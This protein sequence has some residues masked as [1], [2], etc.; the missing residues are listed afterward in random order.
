MPVQ[1]EPLQEIA[2]RVAEATADA[3]MADDYGEAAWRACALLLL[4][5]GYTERETAAILR[6]KHMRWADDAE[7][8]GEGNRTTSGALA[9][10]LDRVERT[11][12]RIDGQT[13]REHVR[14]EL[15]PETPPE[16][17][18]PDDED[19][20]E[21]STRCARCGGSGDILAGTPSERACPDCK[22]TGTRLCGHEATG[23]GFDY[24]CDLPA[25]H[26][27]LHRQRLQLRD[28]V[29]ITNWGD[30]GL[31]PHAT[32]GRLVAGKGWVR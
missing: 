1:T 9:R 28:S 23:N 31:A 18:M 20:G 21:A 8:R 26:S 16:S 4:R 15:V 12:W 30:D 5:R 22:G 2:S 17:Y 24:V 25:G 29:S 27:G 3:Y 32:A 11:D 6:S 10:Y 19:E 14:T 7:G 13:F